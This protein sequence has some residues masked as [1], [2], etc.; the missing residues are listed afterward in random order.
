M[1]NKC[2]GTENYPDYSEI[3]N[4]SDCKSYNSIV[5]DLLPYFIKP[6]FS[7]SSFLIV[8]HIDVSLRYSTQEILVK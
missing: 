5:D 1:E 6:L 4:L 3:R 2:S 8:P 7:Y